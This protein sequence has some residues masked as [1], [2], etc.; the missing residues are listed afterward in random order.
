MATVRDWRATTA[1]IL[2]WQVT[3]SVCFY[4]IYAVTPFVRETFGASATFVGIML[5]GL[6]L[7][8]TAFLIPVGAGI[9]RLGEGR[10]LV[11][12][13]LGLGAL[14]AA[15]P[16]AWD[17]WS[18][19]VAVALL[20]AC[21]AT[22]IPGT[23]K[24]VFNAIPLPRQNTSMGIKQVG[25]TMGSGIS[26]VLVPYFGATRFG[27]EMAFYLVAA[28]AVVVAVVFHWT[29]RDG[30]PAAGG[31]DPRGVRR[32]F[33]DPDYRR[34]T[35]AGF[36]LG[37]GLFTTI[38]YTI[39]YVNESIGSSVVLAGVVLA[40]A[41][42]F[43]SLGRIVTGWLA[44]W[45]PLSSQRASVRI[46]LVQTACSALLFVAVSAV[47]AYLPALVLFAALGFF[48]LGFTG[49]YYSCIGG[50]VGVEEMG[51]AT[52]GGQLALNAGALVAPP[53]F[54]YLVDGV[55]YRP[56]WLLLAVAALVALV[57]L[58]RIDRGLRSRPTD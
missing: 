32:H 49:I 31:R 45:L 12:G 42:V 1:V 39:L 48:V 20:G 19:L 30:G 2:L 52:A 41:Q 38:G 35:V 5:T 16:F 27:W 13:L 47:D 57:L 58:L 33:T 7:G 55:G 11:A 53:A 37:A 54:G 44:D 23:N 22:A 43:G 9:D 3:A 15:V 6:M 36:F 26:A 29:Y 46:L 56:A 34:I 14:A 21:Y 18:L 40:V 25:V 17:Y 51:S 10:V 24:A 28:I 8:Y 50:I 4:A